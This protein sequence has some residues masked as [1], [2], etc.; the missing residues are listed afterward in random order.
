M[1]DRVYTVTVTF[2]DRDD[3]V[4]ASDILT[5]LGLEPTITSAYAGPVKVTPISETRLGRIVLDAMRDQSSKTWTSEDFM[6]LCQEHDYKASSWA[7]TLTKLVDE[8]V[9]DRVARGLYRA[10]RTR[11][12][13]S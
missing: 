3:A 4:A 7:A 13:S 8:G 1:T 12:G 11:D 6:I 10:S 2:N 5:D 9:V